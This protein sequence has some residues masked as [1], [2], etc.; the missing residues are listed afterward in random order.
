MNNKLKHP[1]AAS[2]VNSEEETRVR[3][4]PLFCICLKTSHL[5][6]KEQLSKM[7]ITFLGEG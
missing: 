1:R 7:S 4:T 2:N 3:I 6:C 5:M